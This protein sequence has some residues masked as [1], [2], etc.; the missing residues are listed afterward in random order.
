MI[1]RKPVERFFVLAEWFDRREDAR[2]CALRMTRMLDELET[3]HPALAH[4]Y[5]L[6]NPGDPCL[7]LRSSKPGVDELTRLFEAGI[8]RR[9]DGPLG[10]N[11]GER[12]LGSGH[13]LF[14][15]N[16]LDYPK[17]ASC[18]IWA[19]EWKAIDRLDGRNFLLMDLHVRERGN[20]DLLTASALLPALLAVV[21]AWE[22]D[23]AELGESEFLGHLE[24]REGQR[25]GPIRGGWINYLSELLFARI[26][27]PPAAMI[28]RIPGFGRFLI[29]TDEP[30]TMTNPSHRRAGEAIHDALEPARD[31][32]RR[33][34]ATPLTER[35]H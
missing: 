31:A 10:D 20:E 34:L 8:S 12:I 6:H 5:R 15:H 3:G 26:R 7:P 25:L 33:R 16:N 4:W 22:P 18:V 19:G 28:E 24:A 9:D 30:F 32:L 17:H 27:P 35:R 1:Q 11:S 29:A 14:C 2:A 13:H 21:R 23:C